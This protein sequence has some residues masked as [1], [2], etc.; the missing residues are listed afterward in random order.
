VFG[1][2]AYLGDVAP[3]VEP[4]NRLA[5]RGHDVT[6]LTAAG[7]HDILG[8]EKFSLATYPLDF[9]ASAMHRDA[10]HERL[11]RH[12]F[13]NQMRLGRYWMR[14]AYVDDP[15]AARQCLLSTI[16]GADVVVCHPTFG[17]V[18]V[19]AAQS[20]GVPVVVG[21][22]FPM[23]I[24]TREWLPP[25]GKRS[26][27]LGKTINGLVWRAFSRGSGLLLHDRALN[28]ERRSLGVPKMSG[29][30]LTT[31]MTAD[32]TVM[33]VSRHYYPEEAPD[34][35]PVTW[36]GFSPWPGP[37]DQQVDPEVDAFL[38]AGDPPVLVTL[39]TSAAAC[40]KEAFA[41]IALD[42]DVRGVRSLFL[43]GDA[44]NLA[45]LGGRRGAFVFAPVQHVLAR[46]RAAVVS[47]ALG[48]LA[49]ALSAGVPVVVFPQL[50]DQVWHGGRV[51]DL[52][53][54]VM[55]WRARD[56]AGADA[57]IVDDDAY[58]RR[59][60]ALAEKMA[61]EDGAA[62]LVTAVEETLT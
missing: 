39:G 25:V 5:E 18:V 34:W 31:W 30:A 12:P 48:S 50:F 23:M 28:R 36:G 45:S 4:A 38:D 19:P 44:R 58:R 55:V 33:L 26:P 3:F 41:T 53:V 42:L 51:E 61:G 13:L 57:R 21:Q 11:M 9:S 35:P 59:A 40:A 10:E 24:P 46:C 1:S 43:V 2:V 52:G 17:S 60:R 54:G 15:G 32:R 62:A 14:T 29:L 37:A 20:L 56:V 6:F 16:Q 49:A 27:R 47:G 22:L 7:Y 8:S